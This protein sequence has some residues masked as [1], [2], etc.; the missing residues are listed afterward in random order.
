MCSLAPQ[1]GFFAIVISAFIISIQPQLQPDTGN[2]TAAL[3]RVLL[4]TI[5]NTTFAGNTPTIPQWTGPPQSIVHVQAILYCA[6]SV[7]LLSAFLAMLAKQWL[8]RYASMDLRGTAMGRGQDRQRKLD[9]IVAWYF[10]HV[11][12][13]LPLMLQIA[14]LLLGYALSRYLWDINVTVAS[15]VLG[16]TAFGVI[17]YLF[18]VVAGTASESCPYPTPGACV[19]RRI[20]VSP[21]LA[22]PTIA[23]D[24]RC[25]SWM[26]RMSSD[27]AARLSALK[28]LE[29]VVPTLTNFDP[30]LVADCFGAFIGC[31]NVSNGKAVITQGLEQLAA[32]SAMCFLRTSHRLSVTDPA[33]NVPADLRQYYSRVVPPNTDFLGFPFYYTITKIHGLA[34]QNWDPHRLQW[35]DYRPIAQ[36][37]ILA[38]QDMIEAAQT[39][40]QETRRQKVPRW[41]LRFAFHSLSLDPLPP[42]SVI[43]DCLSI[44]A[45]DLGC[46]AHTGSLD[47]RC[48]HIS[49]VIVTL[50]LQSVYEWAMFRT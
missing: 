21:G 38:A 14:L 29:A 4:Y 49:Q 41:I 25:I 34:N 23:L 31:I 27:K 5:D 30:T 44:I 6:L 24:L 39:G 40:Y 8:N 28:H 43:A 50:T 17:S 18:I 26:L 11:L 42:T 2:E 48:V 37:H 12:E 22:R 33:S 45:I 36:D 13:S 35:D 47:E 16:V 1:A 10:D 9:G 32:V 7:T 3:L 20:F 46:V 19:L 15:V